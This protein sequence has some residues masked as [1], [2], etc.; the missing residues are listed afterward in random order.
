[1]AATCY[2]TLTFL[3]DRLPLNRANRFVAQF[4]RVLE[5]WPD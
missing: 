4:V 2:V 1:V 3:P 5:R